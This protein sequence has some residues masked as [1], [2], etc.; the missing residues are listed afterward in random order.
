MVKNK[1]K[2]SQIVQMIWNKIFFEKKLD[3]YYLSIR[4]D[5]YNTCKHFVVILNL[6]FDL[7]ARL[8]MH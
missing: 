2:K 6:Q 5:R 7:E 8:D 4:K 1:N 3:R